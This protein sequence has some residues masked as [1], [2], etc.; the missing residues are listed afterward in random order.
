MNSPTS[1]MQFRHNNSNNIGNIDYHYED[2]GVV[3]GGY[4]CN[5][6]GVTGDSGDGEKSD[7][8]DGEKSEK[9]LAAVIPIIRVII[10]DDTDAGD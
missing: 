1:H 10:D 3:C 7:S 9:K 6:S 8:G 4:E 2:G 5:V